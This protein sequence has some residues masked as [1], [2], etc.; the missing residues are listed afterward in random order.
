MKSVQSPGLL[1]RFLSIPLFLFWLLHA[2]SHGQKHQLSNYWRMRTR[3]ANNRPQKTVIW[4]HAASVGEVNSVSALAQALIQQGENILMTS[5]TATGFQAIERNFGTTLEKD[6]IPIDFFWFCRH[7]FKRHQIKTGLIVETELWPELLYQACRVGIPLLQIN[8]RL[9]LKSSGCNQYFRGLLSLTLQR[10]S[11]ILTRNSNDRKNLLKLGAAAEKITILGNIKST[12]IDRDE[13]A[14]LIERDY[15]ILASSHDNEELLFLKARSKTVAELLVIAPRHP[16]RKDQIVSEIQ[17]M[18]L[19][20]A[21]RS[22]SQPIDCDTQVYLADTLGELA[23]LM[24]HARIVVMGGSFVDVG[25]HNLVEPAALGC[26]IITGPFDANN[27]DDILMLGREQ[28][29][30]QA[31]DMKNAWG[32]IE[33]LLDQPE[34][35]KALGNKARQQLE[36]QPDITAIYLAEINRWI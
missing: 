14:R 23:A 9:S 31:D 25:G 30:V 19:R 7:F 20:L 26:A 35:L 1:Y 29:I 11:A 8:A 15:L 2:F 22:E 5:F 13:P 33:A 28:G 17:K 6:I 4:I 18:G 12:P 24:A 32:N 21:I 34:R 10:F 27:V 3:A 36:I 16:G